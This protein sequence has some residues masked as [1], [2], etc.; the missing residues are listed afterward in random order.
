MNSENNQN[1]ER[2]QS[3]N[4]EFRLSQNWRLCQLSEIKEIFGE[5]R[6]QNSKKLNIK[7]DF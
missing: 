5:N 3:V 7:S 4:I 1:S 2:V 6:S